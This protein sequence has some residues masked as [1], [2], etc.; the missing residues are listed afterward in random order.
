MP[1]FEHRQWMEID[2]DDY[3]II[4]ETVNERTHEIDRERR[5][6]L[7]TTKFRQESRMD[8]SIDPAFRL[9]LDYPEVEDRRSGKEGEVISWKLPTREAVAS[10]LTPWTVDDRKRLAVEAEKKGLLSKAEADAVIA[11]T[12]VKER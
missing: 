6:P 9:N 1:I 10:D 3:V 12:E 8:R 5:L 7:G 2:G 4:S 11:E